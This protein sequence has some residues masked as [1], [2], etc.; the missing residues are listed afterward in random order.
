MKKYKILILVAFI[1]TAFFIP[2]VF[3]QTNENQS[4][5]KICLIYFTGIG[6]PHCAKADPV[7]LEEL[8]K[9]YKNLVIIEYEIYQQRDNAPLILK[10]NDKYNTGTGIPLIIIDN[11]TK[12]IGD[13][14]IIDNIRKKLDAISENNCLLLNG[15][16][17]FNDLDLNILPGHPKIWSNGRVLIKYKDS[18][19][20][21]EMQNFV[22]KSLF[23]CLDDKKLNETTPQ[24]VHLSGKDI[25]FSKAAEMGPWI[26]E[27]GEECKNEN[28]KFSGINYSIGIITGLLVIGAIIVVF[29]KKRG[30]NK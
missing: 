4:N 21:L 14:P 19:T 13:N 10:Y 3:A 22:K 26:L 5:E 17:N 9:E 11:D 23:E 30:E 27:Y 2:Q 18:D 15:S 6:C 7:V 25:K 8:P 28:K 24:A 12:L 20:N 1:L 29:I 16:V